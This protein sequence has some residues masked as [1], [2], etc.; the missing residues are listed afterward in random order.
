MNEAHLRTAELHR[1]LRPGAP[2][3]AG[4]NLASPEIEVGH[5]DDTCNPIDP[6]TLPARLE[7]AGFHDVEVSSNPFAWSLTARA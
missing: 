1:A 3:V 4:D 2:L 6:A 5:V 7:A